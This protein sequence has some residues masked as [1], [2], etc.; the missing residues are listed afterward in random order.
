MDLMHLFKQGGLVM[1]PLALLSFVAL[2]IFFER[3]LYFRGIDT[4]MERLKK[5]LDYIADRDSNGVAEMAKEKPTDAVLLAQSYLSLKQDQQDKVQNLETQVN[6]KSMGYNDNL[7]FLSIIIT[8]AP[9]LGLLGTILGI[10]SSF[11]VFD[12]QNGANQFAITSGVGEALIATAFGL[13]VAMFALVLYG[14]LKYQIGKLDKKL[15][16]CCVSLLDAK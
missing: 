13:I 16:L 5:L 8:L 6:F 1:Y 7:A 10:I 4:D 15:A 12:L 11:K 14:V 3:M 9:L 2:A